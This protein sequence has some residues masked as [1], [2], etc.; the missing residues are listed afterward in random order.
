MDFCFDWIADKSTSRAKRLV[1]GAVVGRDFL[2]EVASYRDPRS[3]GN[4]YLEVKGR[5]RM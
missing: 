1:S 3:D 5:K 4:Y 2:E